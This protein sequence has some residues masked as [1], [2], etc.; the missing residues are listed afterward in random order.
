MYNTPA[1]R[2][3]QRSGFL[4]EGEL[5]NDARIYGVYRNAEVLAR[6]DEPGSP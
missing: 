5:V 4:A 6:I 1:V 2:V 3:Y